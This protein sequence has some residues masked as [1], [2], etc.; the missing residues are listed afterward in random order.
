MRPI[1]R[2]L[3]RYAQEHQVQGYTI[4]LGKAFLENHYRVNLEAPRS[5]YHVALMRAIRVLQDL[6]HQDAVRSKYTIHARPLAGSHRLAYDRYAQELTQRGLSPRTVVAKLATMNHLNRFF[7]KAGITNLSDLTVTDIGAYMQTLTRYAGTTREAWLYRVREILRF[8]VREGFVAT[9][10]A[11][12]FPRIPTYAQDPLPSVYSREEITTILQNIDRTSPVGK[13][14]Y[15]ILLLA[16][17]LGCGSGIFTSC[18]GTTSNGPR[19]ALAMCNRKRKHRSSFP[20]F[21]TSNWRSWITGKMVA[22][23]PS[24]RR[25]FSPRKRPM[26]WRRQQTTIIFCKSIG[27]LRAWATTH[28]VNAGYIPYAIAW[29]ADCSPRIPRLRSSQESSVTSELIRPASI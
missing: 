10:L 29:R 27:S 8:L 21:K 6:Q 26:G 13:R 4:D 9:G 15:A 17:R 1:W 2:S 14:N 18:A 12:L 3:S 7:E 20:S 23:R 28:H 25:C 24:S 5:Q 22:R 16:A 11:D 19:S